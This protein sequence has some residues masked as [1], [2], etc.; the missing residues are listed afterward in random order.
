MG[1]A[2][3][4]EIIGLLTAVHALKKAGETNAENSE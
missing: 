1:S 3:F 2:I 4:H